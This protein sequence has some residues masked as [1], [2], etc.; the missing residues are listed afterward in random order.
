MIDYA[1]EAGMWRDISAVEA[2]CQ[3]LGE[4]LEKVENRPVTMYARDPIWL[5][6]A[7]GLTSFGMSL[8]FMVIAAWTI[9]HC[10][11]WVSEQLDPKRD[12]AAIYRLRSETEI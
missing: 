10:V 12:A 3:D 1:Q 4:R 11:V 6:L 8:V 5:R 7:T 2:Q 9:S